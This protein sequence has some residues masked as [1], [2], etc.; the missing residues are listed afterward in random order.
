L[1]RQRRSLRRERVEG[2]GVVEHD[3]GAAALLVSAVVT[4]AVGN[5]FLRQ[6]N[7]E[8]R[9]ERNIALNAKEEAET[10]RHRAETAEQQAKQAAGDCEQH[11]L[12]NQLPNQA[13]PGCA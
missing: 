10:A 2:R 4:L 6:A 12:A 3:I 11:A 9:R 13:H 5:V 8:T 7:E 1:P